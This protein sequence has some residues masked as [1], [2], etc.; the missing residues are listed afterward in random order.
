[1]VGVFTNVVLSFTLSPRSSLGLLTKPV[2][3][4]CWVV[5]PLLS[6]PAALTAAA[7]GH[8]ADFTDPLRSTIVLYTE[9]MVCRSGQ[10]SKGT[11]LQ[12]VL[13]SIHE[14]SS[15]WPTIRWISLEAK[16]D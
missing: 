9:T 16:T 7:I 3:R 10:C 14:H 13:T 5:E 6:T 1:M 11:F 2:A 15:R 8:R 4:Q 12:S